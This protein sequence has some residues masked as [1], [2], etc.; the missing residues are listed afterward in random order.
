MSVDSTVVQAHQHASGA[1]GEPRDLRAHKAYDVL[2]F[3]L[4]HPRWEFV[5]QPKY[6]AYLNLIEPWWK[7]LR[8]LAIKG[9]VFERW[10]QI[11]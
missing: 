6:A 3:S 5:F 2:L 1:R 4:A 11:E 10:E 9:R 7:T 8:S